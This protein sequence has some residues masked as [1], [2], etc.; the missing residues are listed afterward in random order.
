MQRSGERATERSGESIDVTAR[1]YHTENGNIHL[2]GETY[3]VT[4]RALAETLRGIGFVSIDGWT[5]PP[6]PPETATGATA[7]SPGT[8]TPAGASA[9][10]NLA[11]CGAVTAS[12][13]SAWA[14]GE[15]MIL[16]DASA[17]SWNGSTWIAGPAAAGMRARR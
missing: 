12:P 10:A 13:V 8:W 16:G 1:I 11:A 6:E 14:T 5:P 17:C 4:E 9:P 2:E 7:G 3:P 15:H